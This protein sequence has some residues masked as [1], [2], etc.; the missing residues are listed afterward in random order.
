MSEKS[1]VRNLT[2]GTVWKKLILFALPFML[3][4]LLQTV[5]TMVDAVIVGQF[6][7][8]EALA[9]VTNCGQLADFYMLIGMG[10]ASAGQI[11]IAQFVGKQDFKAVNRTIGTMFTFLA[12][13][14]LV[15]T[16]VCLVLLNRQLAWLNMPEESL[17]HAQYYLATCGCG[18]IFT[19]GYNCVS[20]ILRGMGDST[21][22]LI[23]VAIASCMNLVLDLAFVMGLHLGAF[24][25]ALATVI[26]QGFSFIVAVI[27]LY[28][29]RQAF[30]FDFR[31]ASFVPARRELSMLLRLGA[32][33]ALQ[34]AAINLSLLYV[35]SL[36]NVYGV[37]A[38]AIT[39]VGNKMEGIIRIVS[40]SM[41]TAGSAMVGQCVGA[42]KK[43]RVP[44]VVNCI[45]VVCVLYSLVCC[46]VVFFFPR[47]VFGLFTQAEEVLA[48]TSIY[49]WAAVICY[50]FYGPRA[51]YNA[52][53][54]GIGNASLGLFA[55]L[56]DGV[57][58]RI[59]LSVL[60][61]S[62]L[63]FGIQGFWYGSAAAGLVSAIITGSYYYSGRWKTRQLITQKH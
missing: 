47:A 62:V 2:V 21:R 35:N 24:G 48:L 34:F 41:G 26:G 23:F 13:L 20:A 5:Y 51:A 57:V 32:P 3:A 56:M 29:H 43:E 36:I 52:V 10:I 28:H 15:C 1:M 25:A 60:F 59:G 63:G 50:L 33:M 19:Y 22:P 31:P 46:A 54:N 38:A 8:E 4:N 17:V 40:N 18:L 30:G 53:V 55:C 42:D 6:V 37:A 14:G 49:R 45:L 7:G 44:K 58:A 12:A 16:G 11:L 39:G 9:A 61:G 27:Y